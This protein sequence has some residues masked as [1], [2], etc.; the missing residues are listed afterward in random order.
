MTLYFSSQRL[1]IG[2]PNNFHNSNIKASHQDKTV[3]HD[4]AQEALAFFFR[5]SRFSKHL[6]E[7]RKTSGFPAQYSQ[8]HLSPPVNR[9]DK[10]RNSG[11][12]ANKAFS[13]PC[14]K[15]SDSQLPIPHSGKTVLLQQVRWVCSTPIA[16]SC[17]VNNSRL[18][19]Q[20]DCIAG[21]QA[22]ATPPL[23]AQA[24]PEDKVTRLPSHT[25]LL[26][27]GHHLFSSHTPS[28]RSFC[29]TKAMK[30]LKLRP[31]AGASAAGASAAES[32]YW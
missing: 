31:G 19:H 27:P 12:W 23:S 24:R 4:G 7:T 32:I 2:Q 25:G 28:N 10:S 6:K 29:K 22:C 18:P 15:S 21:C 11:T 3:R 5:V 17:K 1:L 16:L 9:R 20:P 30:G 14:T 8:K 13:S 26:H